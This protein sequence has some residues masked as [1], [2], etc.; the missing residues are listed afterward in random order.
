MSVTRVRVVC[1]KVCQGVSRI[2]FV[3]V[4][5]IVT[6]SVLVLCDSCGLLGLD[7]YIGYM[8]RVNVKIKK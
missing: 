6:V 1:V 7:I 8:N 2:V 3:L 5:V 4:R